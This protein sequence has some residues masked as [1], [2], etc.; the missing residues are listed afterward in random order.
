MYY[1]KER[2]SK[3]ET[4]STCGL[5]GVTQDVSSD[6]PRTKELQKNRYAKSFQQISQQL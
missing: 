1:A 6:S 5:K 4:K 2:K 3:Q